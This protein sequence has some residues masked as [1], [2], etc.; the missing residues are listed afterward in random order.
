MNMPIFSTDLPPP[1]DDGPVIAARCAQAIGFI[2]RCTQVGQ[3]LRASSGNFD[4]F[5]LALIDRWRD[6]LEALIC[7]VCGYRPLA[8]PELP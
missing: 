3:S 1:E 6:P 8:A 2:S 5:K 4:C 7:L